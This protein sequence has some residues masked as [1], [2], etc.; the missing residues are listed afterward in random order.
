VIKHIER[1]TRAV[2]AAAA[3]AIVAASTLTACSKS[4][5]NADK[6]ANH[7]AT[8]EKIAGSEGARVTLTDKAIERIGLQTAVVSDAPAG[9]GSAQRAIATAA[10]LYDPT[11]KTWAYATSAHGA[12][13]RTPI[14]VERVVGDLA[15]LSDGP[16]TGTEVVTVGAEELYG[17]ES[18]FGED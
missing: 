5:N 10:V 15:L 3:V 8:V 2:L 4:S 17:A 16:P 11:G 9:S 14:V 18:T 7:P 6:A 13:V 1:A 12:Y